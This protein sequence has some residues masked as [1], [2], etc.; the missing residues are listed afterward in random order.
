MNENGCW[1]W[2]AGSRGVGY[3]AMKYEGQVVDAHRVS[4]LLHVGE[5]PDKMLVC[6]T[7]D[8]RACVNPDH[9]FLGTYQDN[10]ID[11]V[12]KGRAPKN[13]NKDKIKHPSISAYRYRRCRRE[14]CR[15][16]KRV[17]NAKRYKR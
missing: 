14:G 17:H 1:I 10:R 12:E 5:I 9:L 16:L 8:N 6:H 11:C 7:C 15:A 3:G 13:I 2:G 4:Y